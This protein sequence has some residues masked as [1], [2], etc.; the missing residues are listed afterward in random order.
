MLRVLFL[1]GLGATLATAANAQELVPLPRPSEEI[2]VPFGGERTIPDDDGGVHVEALRREPPEPLRL[3]AVDTTGARFLSIYSSRAIEGYEGDHTLS[4]LALPHPDGL[5]LYA[6]LDNDEDLGNDGPPRLLT[7][8]SGVATFAL[9]APNDPLQVTYRR[10]QHVP[11]AVRAGFLSPAWFDNMTDEDGHLRP[12][13]ASLFGVEGQQGT[14][15]FDDRPSV[16]RG[17]LRHAGDSLAVGVYDWNV[18]GRF[19]DPEDVLLVDLDRDGRLTFQQQDDQVFRLD[20]VFEVEGRRYRLTYIDPYGRGIRLAQVTE[21]PTSAYVAERRAAFEAAT[22]EPLRS[23]PLD[24]TFWSLTLPTLDGDTLHLAS[25]RGQ[26]FLLNVWGEW[27]GPCRMEMPSLIQ[28]DHMYPAEELQIIGLLSTSDEAA[29]R[30]YLAEVGAS[31]R[32]ALLTEPFRE[33][34]GVRVYST[35]VLVPAAGDTATV[36]ATI[37]ARFIERWMGRR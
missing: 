20:E 36:A 29:A 34:F 3:P 24:S 31:W 17:V 9:V 12:V 22:F 4:V 33:F 14:F 28:A 19:D 10:L 23:Q 7:D 1:C 11:A 25:L 30:A 37:N 5:L 18:N 26:P 6:D 2:A 35:N 21:A 27:C 8:S 32:Q 13:F 16:A 15:L